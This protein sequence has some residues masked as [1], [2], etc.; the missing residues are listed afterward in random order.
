LGQFYPQL[1]AQKRATLRLLTA[2][3][4]TENLTFRMAAEDAGSSSK[5]QN[6]MIWLIL[7]ENILFTLKNPIL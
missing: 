2:I 3:P 5:V 6:G 1:F 7:S 4:V